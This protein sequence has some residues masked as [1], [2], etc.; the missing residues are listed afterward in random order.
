MTAIKSRCS[1]AVI[2][3]LIG[4]AFICIVLCVLLFSFRFLSLSLS[5]PFFPLFHT[6]TPHYYSL[7]LLSLSLSPHHF[8]FSP[9]S[10]PFTLPSFSFSFLT[11]FPSLS[12]SLL[13][14]THKSTGEVMVLKLNKSRNNSKQM[15][16][17]IQLLNR[18]SHPNILGYV[19]KKKSH[20]VYSTSTC[21]RI[22]I[23]N[24]KSII[25][26]LLLLLL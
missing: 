13:K 19:T 18:L 16:A 12:L 15:L 1:L 24:I 11:P 23:C 26:V 8:S 2:S 6:C 7:S 9:T 5:L 10:L 22:V 21:T 3:S 4:F 25:S 20:T 17:E 14:V